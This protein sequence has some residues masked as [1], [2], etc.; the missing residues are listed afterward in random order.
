VHDPLLQ[1]NDVCLS[2]SEVFSKPIPYAFRH[3]QLTM[4]PKHNLVEQERVR[5]AIFRLKE[6]TKMSLAQIGKPLQAFTVILQF[7]SIGNHPEVQRSK[8]TVQSILKRF[9]DRDNVKDLPRTG[10]PMKFSPR[11][12]QFYLYFSQITLLV[13]RFRRNLLFLSAKEPYWG[14][15]KLV[16]HVHVNLV[17]S[18]SNRP[19]GAVVR[20]C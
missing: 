15:K 8:S 7:L 16:E 4:A 10:R 18:L 17:E 19:P 3:F 13:C 1:I 20:V 6:T 2:T 11:F 12:D 14:V 5:L 9:H